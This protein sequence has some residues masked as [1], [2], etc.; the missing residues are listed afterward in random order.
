MTSIPTPTSRATT[1]AFIAF[2]G[3]KPG[4]QQAISDYFRSRDDDASEPDRAA[5]GKI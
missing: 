4:L 2:P 3:N 1:T 5:H